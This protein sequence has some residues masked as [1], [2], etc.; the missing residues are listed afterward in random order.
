MLLTQRT[1]SKDVIEHQIYYALPVK[2]SWKQMSD[3]I[4]QLFEPLSETNPPEVEK[5]QFE[6]LHTEEDAHLH[7]HAYIEKKSM[8]TY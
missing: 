6:N 2:E 5:Q 1:F 3:D 4:C 8:A 7:I